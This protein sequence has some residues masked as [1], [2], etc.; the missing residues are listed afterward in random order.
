GSGLVGD[1]P[2]RVRLFRADTGRC[3]PGRVAPARTVARGE[4]LICR[5]DA[6]PLR[7]EW[8]FAVTL[9][10]LWTTLAQIDQYGGWW[11]WLRDVDV[12]GGGLITGSTAALVDTERPFVVA[13]AVRRRRPSRAEVGTRP[14][15]RARTGAVRAAR[16]AEPRGV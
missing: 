16:A 8:D 9:G 7:P 12:D 13:P 14:H 15:R 3:D 1:G 2:V 11:P 6:V 10:Q 5:G 4:H